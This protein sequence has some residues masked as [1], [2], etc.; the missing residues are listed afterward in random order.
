MEVESTNNYVIQ[1]EDEEETLDVGSSS[2][3]RLN[4][5]E[6]KHKKIKKRRSEQEVDS[7]EDDYLDKGNDKQEGIKKDSVLRKIL[8]SFSV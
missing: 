2:N 7:N 1:D 5:R 8:K 6:G 3:S 4:K